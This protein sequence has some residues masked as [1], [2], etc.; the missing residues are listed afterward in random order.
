M[1]A[2]FLVVSY[3]LLQPDPA[4]TQSNGTGSSQ[5]SPADESSF[6]APAFA[7]RVNSLWFTSLATTTACALWATLMQQWARRY[8]QVADR[9]YAPRIRARIRT[10]FAHGTENFRLA[11]AVEV[12]PALLHASFLLFYAGLVE[13]LININH[14]VAYILLALVVVGLLVYFI[15]TI[16]PLLYPDSPYQTPLTSLCWFIME[17]T[18]LLRLWLRA[19]NDT[20]RTAIR[21]RQIKIG[22]GMRRSLASKAIELTSQ[23]EADINALLWTLKYID[24]DDELQA[25]LNGLPGLHHVDA[26]HHLTGL[27]EGLEELVKP[28]AF[29]PFPTASLLTE[30]L[31][32]QRLTTY[33]GAIWCFSSTIDRHFWAIW[34]QWD[35]VTN[36]PWGP[37]STET[38][39]VAS[40]MTTDLD[41]FMAI[42]AHCVQALMAV[43]WKRGRWQCPPPEA[44]AH[45]DRQLGA[46]SVDI[47]RWNTSGDQLQLAVAANLLSKSLPLLEKL[48]NGADATLKIELQAILDRICREPDASEVPHELRARFVDSTEVTRIFNIQDVAGRSPRHAAFDLSGPWTKIFKEIDI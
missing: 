14:T 35:K 27:R 40:N 16:M 25:F 19:R 7:V 46:S 37:L 6:Q 47:E 2:T 33:L 9:Q 10:I 23:A 22:Q 1:L 30:G 17:A 24:E 29:K 8:V 28:V 31:R 20:V 45:L 3:P 18:P 13:F 5:P 36:D 38:W 44:I 41:P 43:M 12:L 39:T 32:R 4:N 34:E 11:A 21:D 48:E 26:L 42:R 15:L